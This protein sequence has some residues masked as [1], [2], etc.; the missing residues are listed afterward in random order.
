MTKERKYYVESNVKDGAGMFICIMLFLFFSI[1]VFGPWA[2]LTYLNAE[3]ADN[4]GH[5]IYERLE[6]L[7]VRRD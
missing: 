1:P 6:R 2:A 7:E 5:K 4:N 3:Y